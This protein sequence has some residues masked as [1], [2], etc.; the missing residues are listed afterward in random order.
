MRKVPVFDLCVGTY[1]Q[2]IQI[3]ERSRILETVGKTDIRSVKN[4]FYSDLVT[5]L[6]DGIC[7]PGTKI[8]VFHS[9][10]MGDKYLKRYHRHYADPEIISFPYGHEGWLGNPQ[11]MIE[12]FQRCMKA[13]TKTR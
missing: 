5:K 1:G 8:H 6:D 4:Q 3:M 13:E 11:L 12:T 10:K 9:E 2:G 7:A